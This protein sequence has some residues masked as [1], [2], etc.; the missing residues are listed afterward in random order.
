MEE[1]KSFFF[2]NLYPWTTAYVSRLVLSSHDFHVL[3]SSSS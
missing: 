1:L 3:F 2:N